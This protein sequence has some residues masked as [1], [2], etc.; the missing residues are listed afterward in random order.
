MTDRAANNRGSSARES[1][2]VANFYR[3]E[4]SIGIKLNFETFCDTINA[5]F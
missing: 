1:S 3:A 4:S 5:G 2:I